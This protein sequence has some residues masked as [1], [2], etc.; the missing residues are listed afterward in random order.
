[1]KINT[2][3]FFVMVSLLSGCATN[4]VEQANGDLARVRF[5]A[6]DGVGATNVN[7]YDGKN[8]EVKTQVTSLLGRTSVDLF[9][10]E[11]RLGIPLWSYS[12]NAAKEFN[13]PANVEKNVMIVQNFGGL[14]TG[15]A[16]GAYFQVTYQKNKDYEVIFDSQKCTAEIYE[17]IG[18]ETTAKKQLINSYTSASNASPACV[19][20]FK[21]NTH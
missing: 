20:E 15:M 14:G 17:I 3:S 11:K 7:F 9:P 12:P 19:A 5:V 4:Y 13:I 18:F 1:M 2:L 8:C 16:C 10:K 6:K 21:R